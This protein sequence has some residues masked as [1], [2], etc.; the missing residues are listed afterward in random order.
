MK[1]ERLIQKIVKI[2]KPLTPYLILLFGSYAEGG[3]DK[4]SDI[5]LIIVADSS[6]KFME[7]LKDVYM[8]WD[9][10]KAADI[11]FYTKEEFECMKKDENSFIINA[12]ATGKGI[13]ER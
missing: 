4:F 3:A 9:F 6:K 12:L 11:L 5:D 8:M 7:R 1:L 2:Y 13:Y 10:P